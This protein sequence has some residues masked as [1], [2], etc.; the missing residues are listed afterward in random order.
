MS[1]MPDES[2]DRSTEVQP[3]NV[4]QRYRPKSLLERLGPSASRSEFAKANYLRKE[5]SSKNRPKKVLRQLR[6]GYHRSD[7]LR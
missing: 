7:I 1:F 6:Y 4:I 3:A 5:K 2:T